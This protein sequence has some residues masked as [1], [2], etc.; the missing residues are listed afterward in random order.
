MFCLQS[1]T[2]VFFV[3]FTVNCLNQFMLANLRST[4]NKLDTA[5]NQLGFVLYNS[6]I[7]DT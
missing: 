5:I 4:A 2:F 7:M 6:V 1:D 3:T